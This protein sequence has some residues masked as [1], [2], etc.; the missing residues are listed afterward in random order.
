MTVAVSDLTVRPI[1]GPEELSLF[2]R[3]PYLLND[4]FAE[5][6]ADGRRRAEWM[7]LALAGDRPVARLSFWA[8][9]QGDEPLLTDVLDVDDEAADLDRE[10]VLE[11]LLR[12]A[13]A[14]TVPPGTVPPEFLRFVSA[15]WRSDPHERRAVAERMAAVEKTGGSLLVERLRFQWDLRGSAPRPGDRLRFRG[16]RDEQE[17]RE[18]MERALQGSLDAHHR[19][20]LLTMTPEEVVSAEFAQE[21]GRYST[22]RSWWRIATGPDGEPVGFVLPA[23][24]A[25]HPIIGYIAVLPEHRGNGYIDDLLAE[26]TRVLV[27]E[28]GETYARAATDLGNT[29]MA[30]AFARAGYATISGVVDMVWD[31]PL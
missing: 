22:P 31:A 27:E 11:H 18:L 14:A 26:G 5:D 10:A 17:M 24:N 30:A 7:W 20:E 2:N 29:P 23:R 4:E 21:F 9:K 8:A 13:V 12:T 15:D 16:I 6:L 19:H 3:F 1:T 28:G 25:K